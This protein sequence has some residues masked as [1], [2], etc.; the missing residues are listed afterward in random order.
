MLSPPT[1]CPFAPRCRYRKGRCDEELPLLEEL[2]PGHAA[3]C[4]YPADADAWER[5]RIAGAA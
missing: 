2:E 4:F 1:S 5:S 3:A